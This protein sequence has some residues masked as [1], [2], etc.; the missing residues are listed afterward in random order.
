MLEVKNLSVN[1]NST[2][3]VRGIDFHIDQGEIVCL[4]GANGA[5]KTSTLLAVSGLTDYAAD[6]V[7]FNGTDLQ[8]IPAHKLVS[9]GLSHVPE[10]R[11]VFPYLSVEENL[12]VGKASGK[13]L[14]KDEVQ[15]RLEEQY[16]M[17]PR[18]KERRGQMGGTL[19]GGEQ[20]MLA[21]A[22]GLMSEPALLMLDEPTLGL[23]PILIDEIF[24]MILK[25]RDKGKTVLLIEQN[26]NMALSV[27]DRGYVLERGEV[28]LHDTGRNLLN[29]TTV[30][31]AY[32]GI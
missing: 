6:D 13:K 24:E 17:F 23:A 19:S 16:Q 14:S 4:I 8:G 29:D 22:R 9:L 28:V 26:A 12:L 2:Q 10:G 15:R 21:I 25:I 18:L 20:Q 7:K 32:L 1:Y 3:A 27:C 30:Q 31:K 11:A 5:G